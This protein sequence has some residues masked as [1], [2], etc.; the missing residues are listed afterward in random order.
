MAGHPGEWMGS[1]GIGTIGFLILAGEGNRQWLEPHSFDP[2]LQ[3]IGRLRTLIP[4]AP[5]HPDALLDACIAFCPRIFRYCPS[6]QEME[7]ALQDL[8]MLDFNLSPREVPKAW[9]RLREEARSIFR[10]LH[11]WKADLVPLNPP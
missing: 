6:L 1:D 7:A 10:Q 11:L 4:E 8:E 9:T 2:S 5:D 3:P